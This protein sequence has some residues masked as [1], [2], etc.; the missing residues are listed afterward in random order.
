MHH[1]FDCL[2][3][4]DFWHSQFRHL[5]NRYKLFMKE[6]PRNQCLWNRRRGNRYGK[7]CE[8]QIRPHNRLSLP[9]RESWS[10]IRILNQDLWTKSQFLYAKKSLYWDLQECV[11]AMTSWFYVNERTPKGAQSWWSYANG[12]LISKIT[13]TSQTGSTIVHWCLTHPHLLC[14]HFS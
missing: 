1:F 6:F 3:S 12:I 13:R 4:Y 9:K 11:M 5:G 10:R 14:A 8:L 2:R 7:D